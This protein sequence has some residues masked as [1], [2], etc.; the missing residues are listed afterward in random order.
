M[1][2]KLIPRGTVVPTEDPYWVTADEASHLSLKAALGTAARTREAEGAL[3]ALQRRDRAR[4]APPDAAGGRHLHDPGKHRPV[5][6]TRRDQR[7]DE[8][9][10]PCRQAERAA[11]HGATDAPR[12]DRSAGNYLV[13][14]ATRR[15]TSS[16][17]VPVLGRFRLP[18]SSANSVLLRLW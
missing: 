18:A 13:S 2:R 7:L 10:R 17:T 15:S 9:Q 8:R 11:V 5:I 14:S 4:D 6:G 16:S 1:G 12:I 3:A